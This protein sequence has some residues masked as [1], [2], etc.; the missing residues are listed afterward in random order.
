MLDD[1]GAQ[2]AASSTLCSN[3][4]LT[5][6]FDIARGLHRP[7]SNGSIAT[8]VGAIFSVMRESLVGLDSVRSCARHKTI[9]I[10]KLL[11]PCFN[12]EI[13]TGVADVRSRQ[14]GS[15]AIPC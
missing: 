6:L 14:P 2:R 10:T 4:R 12:V 3:S 13:A 11:N 7:A 1:D 8:S 5:V 9:R 15:N